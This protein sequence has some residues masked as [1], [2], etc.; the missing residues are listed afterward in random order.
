IRVG[1]GTT[2]RAVVERTAVWS[3]D[4]LA[5]PAI[6]LSLETRR[7]I[8]A[9]GF[10]AVLSV[11]LMSKGE[12]YGAL[13]AYWWQPYTPAASEIAL[14]SAL[15]GQAGL[16]LENARLYRE[17]ARHL[18]ETRALLGV[19]EILNSTLDPERLLKQVAIRI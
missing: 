15:A 6:A 16:A 17:T 3:H 7:L 2:G 10:H 18:D 1:E 19:E 8:A 14:L 4:L 11:P 9:E 5:D 13:A 12:V